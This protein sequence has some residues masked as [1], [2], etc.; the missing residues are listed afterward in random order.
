MDREGDCEYKSK[1]LLLDKVESLFGLE[2]PAA[3]SGEREDGSACGVGT[4]DEESGR[5]GFM[6]W[7]RELLE[8]DGRRTAR[9]EE[10]R[11]RGPRTTPTFG[12]VDPARGRDRPDIIDET[13][14]L[15]EKGVSIFVGGRGLAD[16][17]G[18]IAVMAT[19]F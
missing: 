11:S 6:E 8:E 16:G 7:P 14:V 2:L 13:L 5:G 4:R 15:P 17:G 9:T 18:E 1:R 3:L 12:L 10:E 19:A